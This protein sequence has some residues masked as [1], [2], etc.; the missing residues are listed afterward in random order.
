MKIVLIGFM[1]SGKTAVAKALGEILKLPVVEMDDLV[2]A[3]TQSK[4]MHEV[5]AKGGELLLRETE[6]AIA[7]EYSAADNCI[8]STGGGVVLNKIILDYLKQQD[9]KVFFL[10]ANLQVVM[11]RLA[12]DTSR[13]L[14]Q[15]F[16]ETKRLYYFRLPLYLEYADEVIDVW[17][18]SIE[19][20]ADE[21]YEIL[22]PDEER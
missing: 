11:D 7:K 18:K 3:K 13:P 8:I 19:E 15:D 14:L 6:I 17:K 12:N 22:F 5:F 21:I 1:G 20:I 4:D 2:Y 10:N 9:G 16:V